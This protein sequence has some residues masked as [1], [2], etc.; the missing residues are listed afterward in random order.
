MERTP[1]EPGSEEYLDSEKYEIKSWDLE[2][3]GSLRA[4]DRAAERHPEPD[5]RR[6]SRDWSLQ[7]H[8]VDNDQLI[9]IQQERE[10]RM[11]SSSW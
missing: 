8:A 4:A 2:R 9:A 7:F 1:R 3:A 6:C 11:K 5:I 10:R